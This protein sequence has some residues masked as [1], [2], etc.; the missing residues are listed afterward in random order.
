MKLHDLLK[1]ASDIVD[2]DDGIFDYFL[3][4]FDDNG[5]FLRTRHCWWEQVVE[6]KEIPD[7]SRVLLCFAEK[8]DVDGAFYTIE[9]VD[10]VEDESILDLNT[11]DGVSTMAHMSTAC[12]TLVKSELYYDMDDDDYIQTTALSAY[13]QGWRYAYVVD[14]TNKTYAVNTFPVV[15]HQNL[16]IINF[17]SD[18]DMFDGGTY[19]DDQGV[20]YDLKAT[21]NKGMMVDTVLITLSKPV[22]DEF[23]SFVCRYRLQ[24]VN[25]VDFYRNKHDLLGRDNCSLLIVND[26]AAELTVS[27]AGIDYP[28]PE[29]S[30]KYINTVI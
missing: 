17:G 2:P 27:V 25:K 4:T 12:R 11:V 26:S 16:V 1:Q 29:N 6:D 14:L 9:W 8:L 30:Q 10:I 19:F 24:G 7:L 15:K 28:I 21:K 23:Q 3:H 13:D 5:G 22:I 20:R 18:N